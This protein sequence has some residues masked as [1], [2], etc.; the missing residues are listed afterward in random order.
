MDW[1]RVRETFCVAWNNLLTF[2]CLK[3][4]N[5]S[6]E[7][8]N[9][10]KFMKSISEKC[11]KFKI[12][13]NRFE[14]CNKK[15]LAPV[16]NLIINIEKFRNSKLRAYKKCDKHYPNEKCKKNFNRFL[17]YLNNRI[18]FIG[19]VIPFLWFLLIRSV[20]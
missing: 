17:I 5:L 4:L 15:V 1:G 14:V 8:K 6:E 2:F 10:W 13:A 3:H 19:Y 9:S 11:W 16:F 20:F 12:S 18:I 7:K